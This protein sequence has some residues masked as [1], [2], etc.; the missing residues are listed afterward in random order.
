LA[1]A[2][3]KRKVPE[4]PPRVDFAKQRRIDGVHREIAEH[5]WGNFGKF[6]G[7]W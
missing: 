5:P 7:C 6:A 2:G 1:H 4:I 3:E